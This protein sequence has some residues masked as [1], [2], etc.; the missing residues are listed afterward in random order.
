M[1]NRFTEADLIARNL[2]WDER[3]GA[4]VKASIRKEE[5]NATAPISAIMPRYSNVAEPEILKGHVIEFTLFGIPMPK[6]SV[7][8]NKNGHFFQPKSATDRIK[9]YQKQLSSILP[10]SFRM[11]EEE[12]HVLKMHFIY[13]PLKRFHK[14][15]GRMEAIREGEI[16]YKNTRPDLSDN[17]KKLVMD[18]MSGIVYKDDGIIVSEDDVK[19]Y[20][21]MGGAI[22]IKLSGK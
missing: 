5:S 2:V 16:F 19:K 7:R 10:R 11:F 13:P 21:G 9:D 3:A 1:S 14:I 17:L 15:K 20:Y 12:V 8:A 22:I 6:Q 18:A 4:Y